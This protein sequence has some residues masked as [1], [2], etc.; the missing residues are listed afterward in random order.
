MPHIVFQILAIGAGIYLVIQVRKPSAWIGQVFALIMNKSHFSLTNWGLSH[1]TISE[2]A[3][4]LDVGCGGGK[5]I[6][7]LASLTKGQVCG[8]DFA[9]G[10]INVARRVNANLITEGRVEIIRASVSKLPF[11]EN[12]FDIVTAVETHYYW[13]NLLRDFQ[14]VKRVL[15]RGGT[16]VL[17]AE[18]HKKGKKRGWLQSMMK[19]IKYTYLTADEHRDLLVSAGYGDVQVF[20][21]GLWICT[22]ATKQQK[23]EL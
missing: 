2:S 8:V 11:P 7:K 17:I 3:N 4:I 12:T 5:T 20:E 15:K 9:R 16:F 21:K 1:L 10:S 13:P 19:K 18:H 23:D 14:E 22:I 6:Q